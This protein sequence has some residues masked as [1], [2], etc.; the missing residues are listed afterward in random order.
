VLQNTIFIKL[1][2]KRIKKYFMLINFL[3]HFQLHLK[4]SIDGSQSP[5]FKA[6]IQFFYQRHHSRGG[7]RSRSSAAAAAG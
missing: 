1:L 7:S 2:S 3:R 6:F 4:F 5:H